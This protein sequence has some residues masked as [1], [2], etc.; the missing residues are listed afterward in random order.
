MQ[1]DILSFFCGCD[2]MCIMIISLILSVIVVIVDQLTKIL[3]YGSPAKSIIGDLLW[4]HSAFNTGVAFSMF[5]GKV[6]IFSIVSLVAS[7][8][9]IFLII[10]KSIIKG[11]AEK[12]CLGIVLGGAIGNLI[13]RVIYKGVRDFIYL[14]FIDFAIFNIADMAVSL[15][16]IAFC[17]FYCI[18]EFK[19]Q[20]KEE[21]INVSDE[22][23]VEVLETSQVS[24]DENLNLTNL[25]MS[26]DSVF[27]SNE[28][29][30]YDSDFVRTSEEDA[31][32][33]SNNKDEKNTNSNSLDYDIN[34]EN[35]NNENE[36]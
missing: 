15:G 30:I 26:D 27:A 16:A 4:F 31:I 13:D 3:I 21:V 5:K 8:A 32:I 19:N 7:I 1:F 28:T 23:N 34:G 6:A 10:N 35:I 33:S 18:N 17:I 14:K 9:L 11:K 25:D 2:K 20:N 12:I 22:E 24:G 36:E 29:N